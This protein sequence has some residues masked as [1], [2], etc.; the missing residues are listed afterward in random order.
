[1]HGALASSKRVVAEIERAW[2]KRRESRERTVL[3]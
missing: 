3:P 1:M 2:A